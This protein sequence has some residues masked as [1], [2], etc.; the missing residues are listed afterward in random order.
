MPVAV[1]I[2]VGLVGPW[3]GTKA[4]ATLLVEDIVE[5]AV[6]VVFKKT[7]EIPDV[8]SMLCEHLQHP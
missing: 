3:L 2:K 6:E 7:R 8:I 4:E 5:G 1:L